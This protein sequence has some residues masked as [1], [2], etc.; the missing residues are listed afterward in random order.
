VRSP[1]GVE[2]ASTRV[3]GDSTAGGRVVTGDH[4][5]QL[6]LAHRVADRATGVRLTGP[7]PPA[8]GTPDS[9]DSTVTIY[10]REVRAVDRAE[11]S[12]DLPYLLFLQGGPGGRSPRPGADAP[13]WLPWAVQRYR[14]ILLDQRGTGRSTPQDRHTLAGLTAQQQ[15]D[16]LA[17]FRADAIVADA[18]ALRRHLLGDAPWTVLGQSFGGFCTWTYL[19]QA[20]EGLTAAFVTGGVPPTG[21]HPDDVYRATYRAVA[22]RTT[23]LDAAHPQ[24]RAVLADVADHLA[25][26]CEQLPTGERL[27]P[28]RLQEIGHVL[29]GAGGIDRLAHLAD[30]A[31]AVPGRRLS[32]TFLAAVGDIVSFAAQP[33]YAV[34]HEACYAERGQVTG[35]SAERIRGELG[36]FTEGVVEPDGVRR[37]PLTGEM[38]HPSTVA[39]DPALAPLA[40]AADL[41]AR[42]RWDEP[43]YDPQRLAANEVP[44]AAC[45]YTQDMYVDPD[46]SR[47]T[48]ARTRS[49][50]IVEDPMHHHDGLRRAGAEI[51]GRLEQALPDARRAA[52]APAAA[53]PRPAPTVHAAHARPVMQS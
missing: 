18:E 26:T 31:W 29:G 11:G 36:I 53:H 33:L 13:G 50:T 43:L 37:L 2:P 30:D 4:W 27:T 34:L 9:P 3:F 14:V 47:A 46:L 16:R 45:L 17:H 40:D 25:G 7:K 22:A 49:V 12:D 1:T 23:A 42:R 6:P 10:A 19:S 32:D 5:L 44:V 35:W 24:A 20:P 48:A 52:A 21:V 51:L 28:A 15:A 38:I 8:P 39:S 41:L